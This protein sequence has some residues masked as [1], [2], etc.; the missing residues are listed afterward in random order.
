MACDELTP[1]KEGERLASEAS[2]HWRPKRGRA[3]VASIM[4]PVLWALGNKRRR[5]DP[6]AAI[7]QEPT[8]D[9]QSRAVPVQY[10]QAMLFVKRRVYIESQDP[11]ALLACKALEAE[12]RRRMED[13]MSALQCNR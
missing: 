10:L 12:L 11:R 8:V 5:A 7:C 6:P 9:E 1:P 13:A 4:R 2:G 3:S